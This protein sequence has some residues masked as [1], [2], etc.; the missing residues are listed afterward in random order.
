MDQNDDDQD[1]DT[2]IDAYCRSCSKQNIEPLPIVLEQ[3]KN[4]KSIRQ[5]SQDLILRGK[6]LNSHHCEALEEIFKRVL[7]RLIDLESCDL[8]C[9]GASALFDMIE[10]YESASHLSIA[11]NKSIGIIGWQAL[12]RTLKKTS[13]LQYLDLSNTGLN[14]QILLFM[15][16]TIRIGSHLVTLHLENAGLFGR[17]LAI[18]VSS[19]KF[20]TSLRELYLSENKISS[21]DCVQIGN[22]LRGNSFLN[23]L[24]LRNNLIQDNGLDCVCEGLS[25][26]PTQNGPIKIFDLFNTNNQSTATDDSTISQNSGVLILNLSNNQLTSR[27]MNRLM[28]TLPQCRS[29]I[30]LDLS[31]NSIGD[32]GVLILKE[33]L[34]ECRTL[35]YLNLSSTGLTSE[36]ANVIA[37][38]IRHNHHLTSIDLSNNEI[39]PKGIVSLANSMQSNRRIIKLILSSQDDCETRNELKISDSSLEHALKEIEARCDENKI[40]ANFDELDSLLSGFLHNDISVYQENVIDVIAHN[41]FNDDRR[42]QSICDDDND[43]DDDDD[44]ENDDE[45]DMERS[46]LD[47]SNDGNSFSRQKPQLARTT[48]LGSW[49]RPMKSGRFSV[50]PVETIS[51]DDDRN[52]T[53]ENVENVTQIPIQIQI[54]SDDSAVSMLLQPPESLE[55][56]SLNSDEDNASDLSEQET[57]QLSELPTCF[58]H[59]GHLMPPTR[60]FRRMSSPVISV[61]GLVKPKPKPN[62][63]LKLSEDLE[64]LDLKSSLPLSPTFFAKYDFCDLSLLRLPADVEEIVSNIDYSM[65]DDLIFQFENFEIEKPSKHYPHQSEQQFVY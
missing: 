3:I 60:S 36:G 30:G 35:K 32:E 64:S 55:N 48:S 61:S 59:K 24:D 5:R 11:N 63:T 39:N 45:I 19:I 16:R 38:V 14:E 62:L 33:A 6:K 29:L 22:L 2:I 51:F 12:C 15:G 47:R 8:D 17:R 1:T 44:D 27:A 10:F 57:D 4:F 50:S 31:N 13:C 21:T 42:N 46:E 20:N 37:D 9:D 7:F 23:V 49:E 34:I 28:Q 26:Q 25:H 56:R 40:N 18:L 43:D 58:N 54:E 53:E 65:S 41:N 52:R